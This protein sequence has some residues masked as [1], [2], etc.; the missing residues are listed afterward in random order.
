MINENELNE[1]L[2]GITLGSEVMVSYLSGGKTTARA[3]RE[4][5]KA[6]DAGI[7]RRWLTG[8]LSGVFRNKQ[9][10]LC[11]CIFSYTRS[12]ED[13]PEAEGNYRTINPSKG[14]LLTFELIQ[15]NPSPVAL[16]LI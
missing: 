16:A 2:T 12:N 9:G 5:K 4:A 10:E 11:V 3:T 7:N 14:K 1:M 8:K 13:A 15:L 6:T